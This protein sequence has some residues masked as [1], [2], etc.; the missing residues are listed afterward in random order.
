MSNVRLWAAEGASDRLE[1]IL[2]QRDVAQVSQDEVA[3]GVRHISQ[4]EVTAAVR[5]AMPMEYTADTGWTKPELL[6]NSAEPAPDDADHFFWCVPTSMFFGLMPTRLGNRAVHNEKKQRL[7]V[8]HTVNNPAEDRSQTEAFHG[9]S[10]VGIVLRGA[11]AQYGWAS[12]PAAPSFP[13]SIMNWSAEARPARAGMILQELRALGSSMLND[14]VRA[15]DARAHFNGAHVSQLEELAV[16]EG[17]SAIAEAFEAI[18]AADPTSE[19]SIVARAYGGGAFRA[20]FTFDRLIERVLSW[21]S[22]PPSVTIT[23]DEMFGGKILEYDHTKRRCLVGLEF[24]ADGS[25]KYVR[26]KL[27]DTAP[28]ETFWAVSS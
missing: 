18:L 10:F 19:Y 24:R 9:A 7:E 4:E 26:L 20:A 22:P 27:A 3:A 12:Q 16:G 8:I 6:C 2:E 23:V 25:T 21:P 11:S 14:V 15:G 13:D 1:N 17:G 5:A 28:T